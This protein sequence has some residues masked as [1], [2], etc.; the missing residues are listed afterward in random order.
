MSTSQPM[1]VLQQVESTLWTSLSSYPPPPN[2]PTHRCLPTSRS[3]E[4]AEAG[5]FSFGDSGGCFLF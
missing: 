2:N 3:S 5:G 4:E 1:E